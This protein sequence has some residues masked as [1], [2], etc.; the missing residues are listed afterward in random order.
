MFPARD[1]GRAIGSFTVTNR[2]VD[3]LAIEFGRAEDQVIV[4]EWVKIAKIG[5]VGCN[6]FVIAAPEDF[7]ATQGILDGLS[8]QPGERY[9]K[10]LIAKKIECAHRFLLH[11]VDKA[12]AVDEFTFPREIGRAH[13]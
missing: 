4:A 10:E 8:E 6:L 2:Q 7:C 5:T 3:D 9:T 11:R 1:I 13:V 12:H